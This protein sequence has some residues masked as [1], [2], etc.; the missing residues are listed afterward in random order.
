MIGLFGLVFWFA[1]KA[2]GIVKSA[3]VVDQQ[4]LSF[5]EVWEAP[6]FVWTLPIHNIS[7]EEVEIE[8]FAADCTCGKVEPPSLTIPAK[9]TREVRLTLDLRLRP[10]Q[11][12]S[13]EREFRL[14]VQ[15]RI[16]KGPVL[17]SGW[18]IRG[19]VRSSITFTPRVVDFGDRLIRGQSNKPIIV[20][21]K[22][23]TPLSRLIVTG[24]APFVQIN[25]TSIDTGC[26]SFQ[27]T[28]T[29]SN[30]IQEGLFNTDL[31]VQP[32]ARE[33]GALPKVILP[34]TGVVLPD[35]VQLIPTRLLLG[36]RKIGDTVT[37]TIIAC[38]FGKKEFD[39]SR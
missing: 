34:V 17:Q 39:T 24:G 36:A 18:T 6:D 20:Q 37:E 14:F 35:V 3:L 12:E 33:R 23:H 1:T 7:H 38:S 21:A 15:P 22:C 31:I 19:K 8:T 25:T 30:A 4:Y 28:V 29:P 2:H 13:A 10:N 32:I 5:G 9:E 11:A 26:D 16:N 27:I